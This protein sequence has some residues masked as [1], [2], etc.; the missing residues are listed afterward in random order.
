MNKLSRIFENQGKIQ[1]PV[2]LAPMS[3][4]TDLPFRKIAEHFGCVYTISEMIA[5]R[6]MILETRQSLEKLK[7]TENKNT[8]H[9]VQIAGCEVDVMAEAAKLNEE[10]GADVIDI[11]Y[12]C[13]VKKVTNGHAGSAMM[14]TPELAIKIVEAVVKA[15]KI[16][17]TV[18]TRM[19]W[20]SQNLNAP[21]LCKAFEEVGAKMITIHGRTRSQLYSGT[22]DWDFIQK[23]KNAVKIPVISNGDIKTVENAR[24]ALEKGKTDGVMIGRGAYGKPWLIHEMQCELNGVKAENLPKTLSEIGE[25]ALW[26]LE[27]MLAFYPQQ[28]GLN[29]AKKQI[30]WYTSNISGSSHFR[31]KMN[32]CES[33]E[34]MKKSIKD[35]F[36]SQENS[37]SGL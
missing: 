12:G 34:F 27:E 19:G 3:G 10:M 14:K 35:F 5:S 33:V 30:S 7:H 21:Q 9:G 11:N 36:F 25:I 29:L 6:A 20:D 4:V 23:V 15:V 31:A 37:Q 32:T 26:H 2:I 8:T 18:K 16:P 1:T 28:V 13:P 24:E 22:A 17:V